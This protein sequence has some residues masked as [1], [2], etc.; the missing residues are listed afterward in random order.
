MSAIQKKFLHSTVIAV[1]ISLAFFW[2]KNSLLSSLTP[3]IVAVITIFYLAFSLLIKKI[4]SWSE[5]KPSID[6]SLTAFVVF[7]IIFSTG[8]LFSPVFFLI[9][10]LLFAV[11]LLFEPSTAL[12][13]AIIS[14]LFFLISPRKDF[15]PEMLQLLSVFL[16]TPLALIFGSQYI[17]LLENKDQ[18]KLLKEDERSLVKEVVDQEKSVKKWTN[19]D[20][21]GRLI[22]IWKNLDFIINDESI[23]DGHKQKLHEIS[24][25]LGKLLKS[26]TDLEKRIEK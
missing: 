5:N 11:S 1:S 20:L 19:E 6:L 17:K 8:T 10:F 3:Q 21:R 14:S 9:Y 18:I 24:N 15:W 22:K 25:Q 7:L 4:P 12:V 13:L 23:T 16:I 26:G 2:T